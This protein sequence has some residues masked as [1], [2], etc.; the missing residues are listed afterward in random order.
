MTGFDETLV[1]TKLRQAIG[2]FARLRPGQLEAINELAVDRHRILVVQRTGWGKSVVYFLT[3]KLLRESGSG[4]TIVIS[5]L[6]ALMR[7][8]VNYGE[9]FG[10]K[11]KSINSNNHEEHEEIFSSINKNDVDLILIS[12]ERL[13]NQVFID[14]ASS[15]FLKSGLLVIDEA[16]CI[17]D[18]GHDFRPDYRRIKRIINALPPNVPVL[19]TTATANNRVVDDIIEQLGNEIKVSRGTLNRESLA[20]YADTTHRDRSYRLA[21][22]KNL[23]GNLSGTGIIYCLT[24]QDAKILGEWLKFNKISVEVYT[25]E[26]EGYLREDI[27]NKLI[28]NQLKVVVAT[29]ALGMGFDKSDISFVIH[30]QTPP[31]PSHYYQQVGRAGRNI[32]NAFGFLLR[33]VEDEDI[34]KYFIESAVFTDEEV[35]SVLKALRKMNLVSPA[36]RLDLEK[37]INI[38]RGRLEKLLKKLEVEGF[39]LKSDDGFE[40]TAKSWMSKFED[41]EKL[42]IY[43]N[44]EIT[45]IKDFADTE[46]C[47]MQ[48]IRELLDDFDNQACGKCDNCT[49]TSIEQPS[50]E[51]IKKAREFLLDY[52]FAFSSRKQWFIGGK[53]SRIPI[54][55][56]IEDGRAL[57]TLNGEEIGQKIIEC[58]RNLA[59]YPVDF[60]E[61]LLR[62]IK[63][64]PVSDRPKLLAYVPSFDPD[65]TWVE[66]L[67]KDLASISGLRLYSGLKKTR[68][69]KSQKLQENTYFQFR[70]VDGAFVASE[71]I[72]NEPIYL[73]DDV[74]DSKWTITVVGSILREAGASKVFPIALAVSKGD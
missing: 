45:Q 51:E 10:L 49:N 52:K 64:F 27:E 36:S 63:A 44:K 56:L 6:I 3:T 30:F 71:K 11:V 73:L 33:G 29:Q 61:N 12:P 32:K 42:L 69:T 2:D 26:T 48:K 62:L 7:N 25:G 8:Q 5:P 50:Q 70:N 67:A 55:R 4:P 65:R 13:S 72:S 39:I 43:K 58:K 60:S 20:L 37:H 16:H 24:V 74:V 53:L 40:V 34:W 68:Q 59:P 21:Q 18:W 38:A 46:Q 14:Q 35:G 23:I 57:S 15:A 22:V 41:T 31:S 9:Q 54:D 47:R 19:A 17:S 28:N 1:L 66:K